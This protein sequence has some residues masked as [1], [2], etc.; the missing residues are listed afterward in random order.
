[1]PAKIT[2][3]V[4]D[5]SNGQISISD[6]QRTIN[7][8]I[9]SI[10]INSTDPARNSINKH[11]YFDLDLT[12]I[13]QVIDGSS[14]AIS[15]KIRINLNL[16]LPDQLDCSGKESIANTLSILVCGISDKGSSKLDV[17]N[18]ILVEGFTDFGSFG[19]DCCVQGNPK[20]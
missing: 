8:Y 4:T 14:G 20:T 9:G 11:H 5:N 10:E 19:Q 16:T 6:V 12:K 15:T 3:K 13:Q 17:G 18:M 7:D 1:M 2:A